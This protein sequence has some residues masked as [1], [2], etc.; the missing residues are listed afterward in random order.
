LDAIDHLVTETSDRL[1]ARATELSASGLGI[2]LAEEQAVEEFGPAAD[3]AAAMAKDFPPKSSPND[4]G[5]RWI[6]L[7]TLIS[8]LSIGGIT[9]LFGRVLGTYKGL[10]LAS[11]NLVIAS[12]PHFGL[13]WIPAVQRVKFPR[14]A[15]AAY[16]SRCATYG[17]GTALLGTISFLILA[18]TGHRVAPGL[19]QFQCVTRVAVLL[20]QGF[21]YSV[22][23]NE[24]AFQFLRR[25]AKHSS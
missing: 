24:R 3:F 12:A 6:P 2:I 16:L 1:V 8:S 21:V 14:I 18:L 19:F 7:I 15:P 4:P 5:Y 20:C 22:L 25:F 11:V 23:S 9:F 13:T 17:L 10:E